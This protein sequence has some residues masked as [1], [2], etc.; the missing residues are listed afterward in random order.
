MQLKR[1]ACIIIK[2]NTSTE[3]C[4]INFVFSPNL[5]N[6]HSTERKE[7]ITKSKQISLIMRKK[8][9]KYTIFI[10]IFSSHL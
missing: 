1:A 5:E 4:K 2:K 6:I 3:K 8:R 7:N 9:I 10:F